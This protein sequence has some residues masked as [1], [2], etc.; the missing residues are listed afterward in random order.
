MNKWI[1]SLLFSGTVFSAQI[2]YNGNPVNVEISD[3]GLNV[4]EFKSKVLKAL[5]TSNYISVKVKGNKVLVRIPEGER[6]DLYVETESG[7]YLFYLLPAD[8]PVE[9]FVVIDTRK[10]EKKVPK[11][12]KEN[13]H[14]ELM[15]ILVKGALKN[16]M[17]A[18]YE[19]YS[20]VYTIETP[21]LL[22]IT[23]G[24]WEG[25][26][27]K[28][29]KAKIVAKNNA[30]IREDQEFWE[31]LIR[32]EWGRPYA[33]AITK[34]FL[35]EGESATL[36]AVVKNEEKK[37]EFSPSKVDEIIKRYLLEKQK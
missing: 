3:K 6:A 33:L 11:V 25:Y 12:E 1:L 32:S 13:E 17:P 22:V 8:R 19:F 29:W 30:R 35:K 24:Y 37:R 2:L 4:F 18:E 9:R 27:Y 21:Y 23:Q 14:E 34:E 15:A 36:V 20:K 5:S 28:V 10:R 7:D 26:A 16:D 31:E